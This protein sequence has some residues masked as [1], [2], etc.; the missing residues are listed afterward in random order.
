MNVSISTQLSNHHFLVAA[1]LTD[2]QIDAVRDA[3]GGT[4]VKYRNT[5]TI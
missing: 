5:K 4:V 1:T 2:D 3:V